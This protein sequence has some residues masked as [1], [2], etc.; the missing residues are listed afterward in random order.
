MVSTR[1]MTWINDLRRLQES[2]TALDSRR[3]SLD[4]AEARLGE[5]EELIAARGTWLGVRINMPAAVNARARLFCE[6]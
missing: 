2:D 6:E 4:D 3:A 5:S 1:D